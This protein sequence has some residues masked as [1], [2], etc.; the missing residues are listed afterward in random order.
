[1]GY[2]TLDRHA[3]PPSGELSTWPADVQQLLAE[4]CGAMAQ[5]GWQDPTIHNSPSGLPLITFHRVGSAYTD[6]LVIDEISR[7]GLRSRFLTFPQHRSRDLAATSS[8]TTQS[9]SPSFN[10][11]A[12]D[13]RWVISDPAEAASDRIS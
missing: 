3:I 11:P 9:R 5:E 1:M 6:V 12:G 10:V 13:H 7:D 4:I 8:E 2:E